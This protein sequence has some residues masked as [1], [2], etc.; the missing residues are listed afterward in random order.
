MGDKMSGTE[1]MRQEL[2]AAL[3]EFSG[4]QQ[5]H[6]AMLAENRLKTLP[7]WLARRQE[8]MSRLQRC[9]DRFDPASIARGSEFAEQVRAGISDVLRRER[10]LAVQV[11]EQRELIGEKLRNLRKGKTVLKGYSLHGAAGPGPRYLS[12]RT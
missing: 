1:T 6:A 11:G 4:M 7:E 5:D 9:L 3:A 12:S 2:A 8:A 10:S